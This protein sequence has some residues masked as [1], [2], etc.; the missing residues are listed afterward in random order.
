MNSGT[1]ALTFGATPLGRPV[2]REIRLSNMGNRTLTVYL[3][4]AT[5]PQGFTFVSPAANPLTI[6]PGDSP[7]RILVQLDASTAG[8]YSGDLVL[9]STDP[10]GDYKLRLKGTVLADTEGIPRV[11]NMRLEN[12]PAGNGLAQDPIVSFEMQGD[13]TADDAGV[14]L[15]RLN[16]GKIEARTTLYVSSL[17]DDADTAPFDLT[18]A[19]SN[20]WNSVNTGYGGN[21][22]E[23]DPNDGGGEHRAVWTISDLVPYY[24]YEVYVTWQ[25]SAT[26]QNASNATLPC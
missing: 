18:P 10:D 21:A 13:L 6:E 12:P 15:G 22:Y 8:T 17:A 7:E 5:L 3:D 25:Q 14:V 2:T 19:E 20:E 9:P 24:E 23:Y 4:S 1:G 16:G 11:E 26:G